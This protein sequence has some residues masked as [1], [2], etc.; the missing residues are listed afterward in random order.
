MSSIVSVGG[1]KQLLLR[2]FVL[3]TAAAAIFAP[4]SVFRYRSIF[5]QRAMS[6]D[7]EVLPSNVVPRH[8]RL[9]L[10]PDF[11]TF[12][13]KGELA[14]EVDVTKPTESIVLNALEL[15]FHSASVLVEERLVG[16]TNIALDEEKQIATL[17][18]PETL[19]VANDATVLKISFTG[20]LNDKMAGFYRSSYVDAKTGEKKWLATTQMG[21]SLS[22]REN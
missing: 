20:T 12:K 8:Y 17:E 16:S 6:T 5:G 15:E 9:A 18:F 1:H 21:T 4:Q 3:T 7:R 11:T 10:T 19:P 14:V 22:P 13:Y 2:N